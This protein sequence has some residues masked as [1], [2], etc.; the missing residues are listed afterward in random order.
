MPPS[1]SNPPMSA[2]RFKEIRKE[3]GLIQTELARVLGVTRM[4]VGNYEAGRTPVPPSIHLAMT[5]LFHKL[6]R[7]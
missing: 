3:L 4:T 5:A 2:D 1:T 7:I 6:P